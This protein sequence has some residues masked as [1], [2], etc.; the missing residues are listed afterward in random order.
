MQMDQRVMTA[1]WQTAQRMKSRAQEMPNGSPHQ[2]AFTVMAEAM[3]AFIEEIA[4]L[5]N[6]QP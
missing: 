5:A 1:A 6:E 3:T 4:N 2:I